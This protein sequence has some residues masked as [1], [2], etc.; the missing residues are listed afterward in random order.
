MK[1]QLDELEIMEMFRDGNHD[2]LAH[3]YKLYHKSLVYFARQLISE[4]GQAED[5]VQD[6]FVKLW[7]KHTD[8]ENFVSIRAFMYVTIKNA[9]LNHLTH[10]KRAEKVHTNI[11]KASPAFEEKIESQ[12]IKA[13]LMRILLAEI[14]NLADGISKVLKLLYFEELSTYEVSRMLNISIDT[15]RVQHARGLTALRVFMK[16]DVKSKNIPGVQKMIT[17]QGITLNISQWSVKLSI[18]YSTLYQRLQNGWP[19]EKAFT[20]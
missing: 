8:F 18:S 10:L 20:V 1:N 16:S 2:S 12:L 11:R 3:I 6:A 19:L 15:V 7:N 9:C 14:E 13:D 17:Y 4:V 5:I